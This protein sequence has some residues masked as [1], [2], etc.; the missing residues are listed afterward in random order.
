MIEQALKEAGIEVEGL[1]ALEAGTGA[2]ETTE[3][4]AEHGARK[5]ISISIER[6]H[7]KDV[8]EEIP[9]ELHDRIVFLEADLRDIPLRG[10]VFDLATAHFLLFVSKREC[11]LAT[12]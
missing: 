6:E 11:C 4:L 12:T 9:H 10:D 8:R 7:L 5:V 3:Y 2:G 1:F